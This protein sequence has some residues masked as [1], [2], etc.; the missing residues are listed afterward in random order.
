[1]Q[2]YRGPE[3]G[4][5]FTDLPSEEA[6]RL[7]RRAQ[8]EL[9]KY[10]YTITAAT[11]T[12]LDEVRKILPERMLSQLDEWKD[13]LYQL[14][15]HLVGMR[16]RASTLTQ[17]VEQEKAEHDSTKVKLEG[18]RRVLKELAKYIEW[19]PE[20]GAY[21]ARDVPSQ[22][23]AG[24]LV[25][26]E[27]LLEAQTLQELDNRLHTLPSTEQGKDL[28]GFEMARE[29]VITGRLPSIQASIALTASNEANR[30]GFIYRNTECEIDPKTKTTNVRIHLK[31]RPHARLNRLEF[32]RA[33]ERHVSK[34]AEL[35][36]SVA[37]EIPL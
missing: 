10:A 35:K 17:L 16:T 2:K 31:G 29:S 1:M 37:V 3:A 5:D 32:K 26:G 28:S 13:S 12:R 33:L 19:D 23:L 34:A 8:E 6:E 25:I 21:I 22:D 24:V 11:S 9:A 27:P 20:G 15:A 7:K 4:V 30:Q 36:L 14:E 18:A